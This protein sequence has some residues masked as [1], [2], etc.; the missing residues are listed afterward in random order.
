MKKLHIEFATAI[1][2]V[3]FGIANARATVP[4]GGTIS[5]WHELTRGVWMVPEIVVA[6]REPD[7]NSVIF[8][9]SS[10]LVVFD[11]GRHEWRRNAILALADANKKPIVAILNSHWHFGSRRRQSGVACSV[12]GFARIC[13][14]RHQRCAEGIS[15]G[16]CHGVREVRGRSLD[17]RWR[18]FEP[19]LAVF[20]TA[21]H[22][23][24][25]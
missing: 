24:L 6:D 14:R 19:I 16:Q 8:A 12:S 2:A 4:A 10:G 7:G 18:T 22:S 5:T 17:C 9:V 20:K 25:M 3:L 13:R 15:R 11:T 21:L 1:V 23:G